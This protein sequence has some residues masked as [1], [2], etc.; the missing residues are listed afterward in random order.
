MGVL[1]QV[2]RDSEEMNRKCEALLALSGEVYYC[3]PVKE[4]I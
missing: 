4:Q 3:T 2:H 1:D